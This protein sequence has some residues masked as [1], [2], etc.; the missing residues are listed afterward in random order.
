MA[1]P[2]KQKKLIKSCPGGW[3]KRRAFVFSKYQIV[4]PTAYTSISAFY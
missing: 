4:M 3:A 1:F 2:D